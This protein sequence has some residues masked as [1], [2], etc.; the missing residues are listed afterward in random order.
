VSGSPHL[1][2]TWRGDV[3]DEDLD[4]LHAASFGE[5]R[6]ARGWTAHLRGHS[7]GWVTA[8][9]GD[10]LVGFVDVAWDGRDHA[11]L[12]DAMVAPESRRHG[13]GTK[14]V[15]R[16][17]DG[18]EAAGCTWLHVDFEEALAPF[19]L[20]RCGFR[21]TRA[22]LWALPRNEAPPRGGT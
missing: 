11:F 22:G 19:Y 1:T 4:T 13:V 17:V 16:A 7:L 9:Q 3:D 12:V 20:A 15:R 6:L 18:A 14:L 8:K 10:H 21:S 5:E 2:F